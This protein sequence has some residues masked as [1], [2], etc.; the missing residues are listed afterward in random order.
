[1]DATRSA[2]GQ[3]VPLRA[4]QSRQGSGRG[5]SI[6]DRLVLNQIRVFGKG[7]DITVKAGTR[8]RAFVNE[9]VY[10]RPAP[11]RQPAADADAAAAPA[12]E[13][14]PAAVTPGTEPRV[15][16]LKNG[17]RISGV[18]EGV[19]NGV[20]TVRTSLGTLKIRAADVNQVLEMPRELPPFNIFRS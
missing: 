7:K 4:T 12:A 3:R 15:L 16:V 6:V 10:V 14:R 13:E 1:V 2:D 20:Y 9:E 5:T 17:D 18:I 19:K 8:L 11:P